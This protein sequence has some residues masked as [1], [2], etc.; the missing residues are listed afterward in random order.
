MFN[1]WSNYYVDRN[2]VY[3]LILDS[4]IPAWHNH[5][6]HTLPL[7]LIFEN[8]LTRHTF[9]SSLLKGALPSILCSTAY[10]FWLNYIHLK[11]GK[12]VYGVMDTLQSPVRELYQA[13]NVTLMIFFYKLGDW[14]NSLFWSKAA[15]SRP[16]EVK[17]TN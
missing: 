4:I 17:K 2:L 13:F 7:V 8:Y 9:P 15:P 5:V 12:W 1:F 10:V 16:V 14:T 3:P 6:M 11:S